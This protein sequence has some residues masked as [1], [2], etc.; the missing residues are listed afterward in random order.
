MAATTQVAQKWATVYHSDGFAGNRTYILLVRIKELIEMS[1]TRI[2]KKNIISIAT[3]LIMAAA[4]AVSKLVVIRTGM[5]L[6]GTRMPL[7]LTDRED[8]KV[9]IDR[10]VL[11]EKVFEA[12]FAQLC[13]EEVGRPSFERPTGEKLFVRMDASVA[14]TLELLSG[15]SRSSRL[16]YRKI[17]GER[18]QA[19][20]SQWLWQRVASFSTSLGEQ[21]LL[22]RRFRISLIVA[23]RYCRAMEARAKGELTEDR[24]NEVCRGLTLVVA[25][26][27][28]AEG[29]P[30]RLWRPSPRLRTAC[31][32]T[33]AGELGERVASEARE[34]GCNRQGVVRRAAAAVVAEA[35]SHTLDY[36]RLAMAEAPEWM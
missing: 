12:V 36:G 3:R 31:N 16:V 35:W 26:G 18:L 29:L 13:D 8:E 32:Y 25:R 30:V 34:L 14:R 5:K 22:E 6:D 17:M 24:W 19:S 33:I 4:A 27:L 28:V 2:Q 11:L 21:A 1:L 23:C 20:P 9:N 7:T 10:S 15:R